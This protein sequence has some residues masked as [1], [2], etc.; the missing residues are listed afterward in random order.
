MEYLP[1][2]LVSRILSIKS[3]VLVFPKMAMENGPRIED[4]IPSPKLDD[5]FLLGW[6][7]I[8]GE[9]LVSGSVFPMK[10]WRIFK[11]HVSLLECT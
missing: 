4:D 11:C 3:R 8:R 9:L 5:S 7:I 2:Q 6:P 1:Y 10:K